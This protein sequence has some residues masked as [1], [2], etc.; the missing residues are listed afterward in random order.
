MFIQG[1]ANFIEQQQLFAAEDRLLLAVS[2][3]MDSMVLWHVLQ[4]LGYRVAV[5]HCN[6]KLR[7]V[8]SEHDEAFIREQAKAFETD[9][10]VQDFPITTEEASKLG[11]SVQELARSRRYSYFEDI[12]AQE[13]YDY[14]L[15][16]HH[17]DDRLE[18]FWLNFVRGAGIQGLSSLR[19]KIGKIRRP[20][21]GVNREDIQGFQ[22][23][24]KIVY[25][26]DSSNASDKYKRNQFRHHILPLLYEWAPSLKSVG[27]RNFSLLEQ[28]AYLLAEQ[29]SNYRKKLFLSGTGGSII[30]SYGQ[31]RQHPARQAITCA[32]LG[33]YGFTQ[34]QCRQ[35]FSSTQGTILANDRYELLLK[36]DEAVLRE[37]DHEFNSKEIQLWAHDKERMEIAN[38]SARFHYRRGDVPTPIPSDKNHAWVDATELQWPLTIRYWESGDR[39]CPLGM[40]GKMQKLQDFFVNNKIDRFDR[41]ST[42]LLVNGDG[43]IIWVTGIRLDDRFKLK[44]S[45]SEAVCFQYTTN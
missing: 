16:A 10:H 39:F 9:L 31:V 3:G 14:L 21:L 30:F 8:E 41:M 19:P 22:Q 33:E 20:L 37:R 42:P 28:Q 36:A 11:M 18:T 5:A 23:E 27:K 12:L 17:L 45:T 25:R 34:E 38:T 32:L 7:G 40:K 1:I 26:E 15:T 35:V 2:G 29:V 13:K 6:F 4:K 43:R 44:S 24:Q